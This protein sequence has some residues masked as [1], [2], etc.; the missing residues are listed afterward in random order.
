M[1][2]MIKV[3]VDAMGGDYAPKEA[4]K[5]SV[6]AVSEKENVQVLLVGKQEVLEQELSQCSYPKERI[7]IVPASEV[8]ETGEPP[9]AAI[10]SKKDSFI[11]VGMKMVRKVEAD[12]C[13]SA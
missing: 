6:A 4:V 7:Q 8:I 9:V 2:N 11:V 10:R 12:A 13:V 5:G 3:A 1:E